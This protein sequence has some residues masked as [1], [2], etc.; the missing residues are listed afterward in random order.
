MRSKS[1]LPCWFDI[2]NYQIDRLEAFSKNEW[3]EQFILRFFLTENAGEA[4]ER[5]NL[6]LLEKLYELIVSRVEENDYEDVY[7]RIVEKEV[8]E[9]IFH[10]YKN[11]RLLQQNNIE[12]A[13]TKLFM[14]KFFAIPENYRYPGGAITYFRVSRKIQRKIR[15]II[16]APRCDQQASRR[17]RPRRNS[18]SNR[19]LHNVQKRC[20]GQI[21]RNGLVLLEDFFAKHIGELFQEEVEKLNLA[22]LRR[23]FPETAELYEA[24]KRIVRKNDVAV[25]GLSE[26]E[27][28]I[29][30]KERNA[31]YP[32]EH[33]LSLQMYIEQRKELDDEFIQR[34][35]AIIEAGESVETN[36]SSMAREELISLVNKY[37]A[38]YAVQPIQTEEGRVLLSISLSKTFEEIKDDLIEILNKEKKKREEELGLNKLKLK[39]VVSQENNFVKY[40]V[41]PCYDLKLAKDLMETDVTVEVIAGQ[42]I[43]GEDYNR[44]KNYYDT[45]HKWIKIIKSKLLLLAF[46]NNKES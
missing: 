25:R 44:K 41:L 35:K 16:E 36:D 45:T 34:K 7:L 33:P 22:Q 13:T 31:I 29:G 6:C 18:S 43:P 32:P 40:N 1:S 21:K 46:M 20:W 11:T 12:T 24:Y 10:L 17:G 5:E 4:I 3:A 30:L 14:N 42:L 8:N 2:E 9:V 26:Y 28:K 38:E 19:K 23:L 39:D 15:R 37:G 27:M